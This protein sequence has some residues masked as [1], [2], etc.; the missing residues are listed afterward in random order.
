MARPNFYF[1]LAVLGILGFGTNSM[2]IPMFFG[3][4]FLAGNIAAFVALILFGTAAGVT[5]GAVASAYSYILWG[6]PYF[7]VLT[8][9]QLLV[10]GS[11]MNFRAG[12]QSRNLPAWCTSYWLLAGLPLVA[13][14]YHFL[15]GV[16]WQVAWMIAFKQG[17]NDITNALFSALALYFLPIRRWCGLEQHQQP[18]T[19]QQLQ[20]NLIMAFSLLTALIIT[21][22]VS[23]TNAAAIEEGLK[24][25][26]DD[27]AARITLRLSKWHE[28][29]LRRLERVADEIGSDARKVTPEVLRHYMRLTADSEQTFSGLRIINSDGTVSMISEKAGSGMMVG[30]NHA[31]YGW[32]RRLRETRAP[33]ADMVPKGH[34]IPEPLVIYAAPLGGGN[35]P[36][37]AGLFAPMRSAVFVNL[38][39]RAAE[40]DNLRLTLLNNAGE[41]IASS[42]PHFQANQPFEAVRGGRIEARF[43]NIYRLVP[44]TA[45]SA[46]QRWIQ[47]YYVRN[48]PFGTSGWTLVTEVPLR[49]QF[50]AL[51]QQTLFSLIGTFAI[52]LLALL[53]GYLLSRKITTPLRQ[54]SA[55]TTGA[56]DNF[57]QGVELGA[58]DS[59]LAEIQTLTDNFRSM[60]NTLGRNYRQLLEIQQDLERRVVERTADLEFFR[61]LIE[62]S[63]DPVF[64]IDDDDGCRMIYVNEAAVKHYGLPREE[65]LKWRIPDWDPNF[66]YAD[67]PKHVEEI[68]KLGN[69][70]IESTHRIKGGELVPVEISLNPIEYKGHLCHFGYFRNITQ[71][72]IEQKSLIESRKVLGEIAAARPFDQ[73]LAS[74]VEFAESAAPGTLGSIMLVDATNRR[75][76]L[77]AA[78]HLPQDYNAKIDGVEYADG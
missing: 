63:G 65:I 19:V 6:H 17:V 67:L 72:K 11:A 51:Q 56:A 41:I 77:G 40:E 62:H 75:L 47:A 24:R 16:E 55:A 64:A 1:F 76:S 39:I 50:M 12:T 57:A 34:I 14:T 2:P 45:K 15:L 3:V 73:M 68:K 30:A 61:L 37:T 70:T 42:E 33:L 22:I 78:P 69:L 59:G 26:A 10:V 71:R 53:T 46:M 25:R 44:A 9:F 5:V 60:A 23:Q 66:S 49:E 29:N 74:I 21:V 13:C 7:I 27:R 18:Q 31:T 35:A 58:N 32:F 54:L 8:M 4:D 43:D 28:E 36:F 20:T 52:G 48:T 38:L